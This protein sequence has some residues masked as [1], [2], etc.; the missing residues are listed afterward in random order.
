MRVNIASDPRTLVAETHGSILQLLAGLGTRLATRRGA[1]QVHFSQSDPFCKRISQ[2]SLPDWEP[3]VVE[4]ESISSTDDRA[5][6]SF[7]RASAARGPNGRAKAEQQ[8]GVLDG[9]GEPSSVE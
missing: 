6:S 2:S 5:S 4:E 1:A 7:Q 8:S 3:D 9:V